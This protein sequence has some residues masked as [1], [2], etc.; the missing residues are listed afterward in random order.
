MPEIT[1][2]IAL[3]ADDF[4]VSGP[5][6]T[7]AVFIVNFVTLPA[8]QAHLEPLRVFHLQAVF[9]LVNL[10]SGGDIS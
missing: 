7:V 8:Q 10:I 4:G 1:T 6:F 3:P 5:K 9:K 2:S